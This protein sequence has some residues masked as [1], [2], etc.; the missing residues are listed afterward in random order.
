MK[1]ALVVLLIITSLTTYVRPQESALDGMVG[2]LRGIEDSQVQASL[3][4]G[5]LSGLSGQREVPMPKGWA[6]LKLKLEETGDMEVVNLVSQ[7]SQIFGDASASKE[8]LA[9]LRDINAT[10][11][12]RR[13]ALKSLLTQRHPEV[14][15]MLESLLDG[16][17]Q[18]E[19][20]R[21]YATFDFKEA[22]SILLKRYAEFGANARRATVETLAARKAYARKLLNA[23][24]RGSLSKSDIPAYVARGLKMLLGTEFEKVYGEVRKVS[25]D[26]SEL[27]SQYKKKLMSP[28]MAMADPSKGRVVYNQVCAACHVMYGEGGKIGP[29]LTGSNRADPDYILLNM[30]DPSYDVPEGYRLVTVT[31]KDGRVYAGNVKEEDGTRLVL[32]MVG[33]T[34]VIAKSDILSRTVSDISLMPEGLLLTLS[35]SQFLDLIQYLRTEQQVEL[36]K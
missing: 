3:L 28:E 23:L 34:S 36:P 14:P 29:E 7:L 21:A 20:I 8:A 2:L 17:L 6:E 10:T 27:I 22:P 32:N 4:K 33:Q 11:K 9:L 30:L 1:S 15:S 12:A 35:D 13:V 26:K 25:A 18:L 31:A 24:N 19:A 16:P 5:M